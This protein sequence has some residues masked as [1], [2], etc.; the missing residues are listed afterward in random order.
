MDE[1]NAILKSLNVVLTHDEQQK[2]QKALLVLREQVSASTS[3]VLVRCPTTSLACA[4]SVLD[5]RVTER[6]IALQVAVDG[7]APA[8]GQVP[9]N[10]SDGIDF[11]AFEKLTEDQLPPHLRR[12][13]PSDRALIR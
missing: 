10:D 8:T 9:S 13:R 5:G 4:S 12:L 11:W 7:A 3:Y 2:L 1:L 6:S